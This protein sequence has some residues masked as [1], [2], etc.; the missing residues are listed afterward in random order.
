MSE[1]SE[2]LHYIALTFLHCGELMLLSWMSV[3]WDR[4]DLAMA[5]HRRERYQINARHCHLRCPE[6]YDA[7]D[8]KAG[9]V[10][11]YCV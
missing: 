7:G 11:P 9:S 8:R 6:S 10:Q 5:Q 3:A 4:I 1:L 2:L